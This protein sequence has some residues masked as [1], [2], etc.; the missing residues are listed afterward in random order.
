MTGQWFTETCP[1]PSHGKLPLQV[2]ATCSL[3]SLTWYTVI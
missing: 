3:L 2:L 1:L